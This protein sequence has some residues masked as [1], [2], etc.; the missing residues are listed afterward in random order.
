MSLHLLFALIALLCFI[1]A[2]AGVSSRNNLMAL[3]LVFLTLLIG[4]DL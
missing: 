1:L 4:F 2:A 3:G